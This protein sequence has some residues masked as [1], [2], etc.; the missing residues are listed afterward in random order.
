MYFSKIHLPQFIYYYLCQFDQFLFQD[1][2]EIAGT[3]S[4]FDSNIGYV[5]KVSALELWE[6]GY[7]WVSNT[8]GSDESSEQRAVH[9]WWIKHYYFGGLGG[10]LGPQEGRR[11]DIVNNEEIIKIQSSEEHFMER[12][13]MFGNVSQINFIIGYDETDLGL[14][15]V[16]LAG[17]HILSFLNVSFYYI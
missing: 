17:N 8:Y 3:N 10:C 7:S 11:S 6:C 4:Q 9:L 16:C 1:R 12:V 15:T 2:D 5:C 14:V 13:T